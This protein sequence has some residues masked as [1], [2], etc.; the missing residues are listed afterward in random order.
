MRAIALETVF[1]L[2]QD[3]LLSVLD[4]IFRSSLQIFY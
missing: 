1:Q 4:G 3:V 2:L